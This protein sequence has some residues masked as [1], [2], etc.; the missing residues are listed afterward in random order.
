MKLQTIVGCCAALVLACAMKPDVESTLPI[1]GDT[2]WLAPRSVAA[3]AELRVYSEAL[4]AYR[5]LNGTIPQTAGRVVPIATLMSTLRPK[6]LV[7]W[8]D[9]D[10]WGNDYQYASKA[11]T[12]YLM[13]PGADMTLSCASPFECTP[14]KGGHRD[15][16]ADVVLTDGNL[17]AWYVSGE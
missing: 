16:N 9:R 10:P 17:C 14:C 13:S 7:N 8:A 15:V 3:A 11:D 2:N 4:E 12:Y 1:D 6:Y 5:A